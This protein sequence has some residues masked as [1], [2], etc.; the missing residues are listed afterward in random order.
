MDNERRS[1][2]L[3]AAATDSRGGE[4]RRAVARSRITMQPETA[5][6]VASNEMNKGDV[7]GTAR[8]A[9]VQSAKEADAYLP[10][11]D[12]VLVNNVTVNFTVGFDFIEVEASAQSASDH[13][14]AMHALTAATVA[15]LTVYDMCKAVDRTMVIGPVSLASRD[16]DRSHG[17]DPPARDLLP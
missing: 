14:V 8:F 15:A 3:A 7:L 10:L 4:T 11:C 9:G 13:G 5:T 17:S 6:K 16:S 2:D 12:P 1:R